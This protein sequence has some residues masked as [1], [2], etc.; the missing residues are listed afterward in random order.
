METASKKR[1]FKN[2]ILGNIQNIIPAAIFNSNCLRMNIGDILQYFIYLF[3]HFLT[4]NGESKK[5]KFITHC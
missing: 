2:L 5:N 4:R 3:D 1:Q